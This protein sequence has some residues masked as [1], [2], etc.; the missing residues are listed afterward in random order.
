MSQRKEKKKRE[1]KFGNTSRL[2]NFRLKRTR[3]KIPAIL[4][5]K[6]NSI[7]EEKSSD[8][9]PAD[10]LKMMNLPAINVPIIK[11]VGTDAEIIK[12]LIGQYFVLNSQSEDKNNVK[13]TEPEEFDFVKVETQEEEE[14]LDEELSDALEEKIPSDIEEND[15]NNCDTCDEAFEDRSSLII[16]KT[17]KSIARTRRVLRDSVEFNCKICNIVFLRKSAFDRHMNYC[18]REKKPKIP[19]KKPKLGPKPAIFDYQPKDDD[20]P[21]WCDQCGNQFK[22]LKY[23]KVHLAQVH[24][25]SLPCKFCNESF[26]SATYLQNHMNEKHSSD[27]TEICSICGKGFFQRQH[28]KVHLTAHRRDERLLPCKVCDQTFRHEVYLKK[29]MERAHE[30]GDQGNDEQDPNKKRNSNLAKKVYKCD[31]CE[32]ETTYKPCF[33]EHVYKHTGEDKISCEL[34]GRQMRQSYLKIHMRIHTG[35]KPEICEFCGKAFSAKKYLKKHIVVHTKEKPFECKTC[36]KK[37]TQ[38]GTLTLHVRKHHPEVEPIPVSARWKSTRI[39]AEVPCKVEEES[40]NGKDSNENEEVQE[41][42]QMMICSSDDDLKQE[43][44][45]KEEEVEEEVLISECESENIETFEGDM[46]I[47]ENA[48]RPEDD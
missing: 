25:E 21:V 8:L 48:E 39:K 23:L 10:K 36:G 17:E 27:F 24:A 34:C 41:Q 16:H 43:E 46:M 37:Y 12:P 15:N 14:E 18:S 11:I 13:K 1:K 22:K 26:K 44:V 33:K 3:A 4:Q 2:F 38:G 47:E 29:H 9:T 35:E 20:G 28:Y 45:E 6:R 40:E 7:D 32:Y 30:N 19:S 5:R 42:V 31:Y